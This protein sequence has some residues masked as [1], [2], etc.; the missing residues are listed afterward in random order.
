MNVVVGQANSIIQRRKNNDFTGMSNPEWIRM[1]R[2]NQQQ[3]EVRMRGIYKKIMGRNSFGSLE[4]LPSS[5]LGITD[6]LLWE[7]ALRIMKN[8]SN[9]TARKKEELILLMY[10]TKDLEFVKHINKKTRNKELQLHEKCCRV[11]TLETY[12]GGHV[13]FQKG[14][15]PDKFYLILKGQ[16]SIYVPKDPEAI[17][18]EKDRLKKEDP[19]FYE[20]I[21]RPSNFENIKKLNKI[22]RILEKTSI[23]NL[24]HPR[25]YNQKLATK[26]VFGMEDDYE[27]DSI[28]SASSVSEQEEEAQSSESDSSSSSSSQDSGDDFLMG[29]GTERKEFKKKV[30][31]ILGGLSIKE[32]QNQD[33]WLDGGVFKFN[34]VAKLV[35]GQIFGE[36]GLLTDRPRAGMAVATEMVNLAVMT[37]ENYHMILMEVEHR[38]L[39]DKIEFFN[40]HLFQNTLFSVARNNIIYDFI[41]RTYSCNQIIYKEG[42][43][44]D[45]IYF[46]RKGQVKLCKTYLKNLGKGP[47][48]KKEEDEKETDYGLHSLRRSQIISSTF[49]VNSFRRALFN[50]KAIP[51][52]NEFMKK[53][54]ISMGTGEIFGHDDVIFKRKRQLSAICRSGIVRIYFCP[55]EKYWRFKAYPELH[56]LFLKRAEKSSEFYKKLISNM[57]TYR[58]RGEKQ[59]TQPITNPKNHYF[60]SHKPSASLSNQNQLDVHSLKQSPRGEDLGSIRMDNNYISVKENNGENSISQ[61]DSPKNEKNSMPVNPENTLR[62]KVTPEFRNTKGEMSPVHHSE[63]LPML[64]RPTEPNDPIQSLKSSEIYKAVTSR[65]RR[66]IETPFLPDPELSSI[67]PSKLALSQPLTLKTIPLFLGDKIWQSSNAVIRKT[68]SVE[69]ESQKKPKE[70]QKKTNQNLQSRYVQ[71]KINSIFD[72][73]EQS[74]IQNSIYSQKSTTELPLLSLNKISVMETSD[75]FRSMGHEG[76]TLRKTKGSFQNGTETMRTRYKL[77]RIRESQASKSNKEGLEANLAS[78]SFSTIGTRCL[79]KKT[80]LQIESLGNVEILQGRLPGAHERG[81]SDASGML[82]KKQFTLT[83]R[84]GHESSRVI[85]NRMEHEVSKKKISPF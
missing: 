5:K 46:I 53:K 75:I 1:Q 35:K 65:M 77:M 63:T 50:N 2:E 16:V 56:E 38:R 21:T 40:K 61:W 10:V 23:L 19:E 43:D 31:T 39:K 29:K 32:I 54:L 30:K 68:L 36:L 73:N 45:G 9:E 74:L 20:Q 85:S 14:E 26:K 25:K 27:D 3:K 82:V 49:D 84:E 44:A 69:R 67:D 8:S 15:L 42:D 57:E 7:H 83:A 34:C 70:N 28:S 64:S 4:F 47:K 13:I 59:E 60:F 66:V 11:L 81:K 55:A 80:N 37:K 72:Q 62:T 22:K 51:L 48:F 41:K 33:F 52:G 78:S 24:I 6:E 17:K 58:V 71:S 79:P 18:E 12:P 76:S